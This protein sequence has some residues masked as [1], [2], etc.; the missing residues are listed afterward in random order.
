MRR[1]NLDIFF[2]LAGVIFL[3]S[4]VLAFSTQYRGNTK[5]PTLAEHCYYEEL[6]LAVPLNETAFPVNHGDFCAKVYCREDYV[7]MI[8]HCDR[9]QLGNRCRFTVS[10]YT[11][12]YPDC[13]AKQ[14]C[15]R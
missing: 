2:C 4:Q 6:E 10:D 12:P 13:C 15:P 14:I 8:K 7:L 1:W 11:K 9:M 3:A 5:H